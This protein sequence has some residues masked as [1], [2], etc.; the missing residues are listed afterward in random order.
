MNKEEVIKIG[1]LKEDWHSYTKGLSL[2]AK[3]GELIE[4]VKILGRNATNNGFIYSARRKGFKDL[5][6]INESKLMFN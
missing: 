1:I 2:Y 3:K 5:F 6:P 4:C